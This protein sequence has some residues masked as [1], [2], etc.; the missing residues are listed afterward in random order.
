MRR[1]K[2]RT[3]ERWC[4]FN[5]AEVIF[6]GIIYDKKAIDTDAY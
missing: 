5:A 1:T 6:Q 4:V 3:L 2:I